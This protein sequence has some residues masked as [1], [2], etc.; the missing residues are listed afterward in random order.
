MKHSV[1]HSLGHEMARK[2]AR[3]AFSAYAKRFSEY[4]PTTQW[5]SDDTA[6]IGFSVKGMSIKGAVL[7]TKQSIDIDLSVPFLMKP[8]QGKAVAV[9]EKE[10]KNW[11]RKAES[12]EID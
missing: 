7:V 9:I 10:I 12:G 11:I 5:K 6:D 3:A 1:P 4:N 8:F 2:V